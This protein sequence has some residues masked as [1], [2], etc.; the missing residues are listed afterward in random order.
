MNSESIRVLVAVKTY[1]TLSSE[2]NE[3]V[4]TAGF[5]E[6]GS[7]IRIYPVPFRF[8]QEKQQYKKWQWI[9]VKTVKNN[10]DFRPESYR[11]YDL[12]NSI[13]LEDEIPSKNSWK[14]RSE[15]ALKHVWNNM[16][17]LAKAAQRDNISLATLKPKEVKNFIWERTSE[18]WDHKK[19]ER[20]LSSLNQG[21]LFDTTSRQGFEIAKKIPF[22]FSYVF[23]TEDGKERTMMIEDW[24]LGMLYL[25]MYNKFRNEEVA[26][27][28]VKE[29]YFRTMINGRD[30]YFFVG[31]TLKF[32][33]V[34][35]ANPFIIIGTYWPPLVKNEEL[36]LFD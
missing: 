15:F 23:S 21:S 34:N 3:L 27:E 36:S 11:P 7:W 13:K 35:V 26:C 32:H 31:T 16:T 18:E 28:K 6:D 22:K 5:R 1:P 2:Y 4:C 25:K 30:L 9:R 12:E 20:I 14:A 19:L 33:K 8:L 10:K 17:E 24:E 29:K